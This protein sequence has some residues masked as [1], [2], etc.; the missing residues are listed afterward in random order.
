MILCK[1]KHF[2]ELNILGRK[3]IY[4]IYPSAQGKG[5]VFLSPCSKYTRLFLEFTLIAYAVHSA[6]LE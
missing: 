6:S 3:R 4:R 5:E 1:C 2:F